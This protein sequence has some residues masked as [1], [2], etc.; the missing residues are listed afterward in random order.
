VAA[1]SPRANLGRRTVCGRPEQRRPRDSKRCKPKVRPVGA[2]FFFYAGALKTPART[3]S[4]ARGVNLNC[5]ESFFI[6]AGALKTPARNGSNA[7]GVNLNVG[8]SFLIAAGALKTLA[9]TGSNAQGVNLNLLASFF[10]AA[11][12]LKAPN[13]QG[14]KRST[15]HTRTHTDREQ[16]PQHRHTHTRPE[17]HPKPPN[18]HP[19]QT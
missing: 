13:A 15:G 9:I 18:E 7:Q 6:A 1:S 17:Q 16:H 12:A 5:G 10:I 2:S 8:E 11:R 14:V 19:P 4:N 3:G